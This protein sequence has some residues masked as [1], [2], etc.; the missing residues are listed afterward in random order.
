MTPVNFQ[1]LDPET[2]DRNEFI[3][4]IIHLIR[5]SPHTVQLLLRTDA[6][7]ER[8]VEVLRLRTGITGKWEG[9]IESEGDIK[10][11]MPRVVE[12]VPISV[13]APKNLPAD[14]IEAKVFFGTLERKGSIARDATPEQTL[15]HFSQEAGMDDRWQVDRS[16]V[17]TTK[18]PPIVVAKRSELREFRQALPD[19]VNV[20]I[21]DH[22]EG[23]RHVNQHR[24]KCK[25][26]ES[27]EEQALL[28]SNGFTKP[29]KITEWVEETDGAIYTQ[30]SRLNFVEIRFRMGDRVIDSWMQ[31]IATTKQKEKLATVLFEQKVSLK[32]IGIDDEGVK[33]HFMIPFAQ[34]F[35]KPKDDRIATRQLTF[36]GA[37]PPDRR[38]R[39]PI[40][41]RKRWGGLEY[42]QTRL[43]ED[44]VSG[45]K[46]T[47]VYDPT[48]R[49]TE[50]GP[51]IEAEV[52]GAGRD[53][54]GDTFE[55]RV[56]WIWPNETTTI[57]NKLNILG[58]S[59]DA[60]PTV[61]NQPSFED[62]RIRSQIHDHHARR[63]ET[64]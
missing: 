28:V 50:V 19:G 26:G 11:N 13:T 32:S 57:I 12:L 48:Q 16:W 47:A 1:S 30:C 22:V 5:T 33:T 29:M 2:E 27:P 37:P 14:L 4:K 62:T 39:M 35:K 55:R 21:A 52:T 31:T 46:I 3:P 41:T 51:D 45:E 18:S 64:C 49:L 7:I 42:Q 9:R 44:V 10:R 6:S 53:V 61:P 15:L 60:G 43:V 34:R 40:E 58:E 24:I 56:T 25:G 8:I 36:P 17:G 54:P 20:F 38:S 59:D 63:L 23:G